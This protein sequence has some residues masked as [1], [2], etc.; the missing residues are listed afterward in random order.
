MSQN[1][2]QF[3]ALALVKVR[4]YFSS[5]GPSDLRF[6]GAWAGL[7]YKGNPSSQSSSGIPAQLAEEGRSTLRPPGKWHLK[8]LKVF[9]ER[10][11]FSPT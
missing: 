5:G 11:I 8:Y 10:K 2:Y 9:E 3:I 7:L 6:G 1:P 4:V